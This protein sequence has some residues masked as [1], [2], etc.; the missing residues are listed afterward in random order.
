MRGL[1]LTVAASMLM[2]AVGPAQDVL[3]PGRA[4]AGEIP[5]GATHRVAVQLGGDDYVTAVPG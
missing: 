3:Q 5:P 1:A 4:I 2:Y